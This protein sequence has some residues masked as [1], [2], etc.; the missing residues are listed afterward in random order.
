MD[1]RTSPAADSSDPADNKE[2]RNESQ[3]G[4]DSHDGPDASRKILGETAPAGPSIPVRKAP[5]V[6]RR[7]SLEGEDA[8]SAGEPKR[9]L[10]SSMVE[11]SEKVG[12]A[13]DPTPAENKAAVKSRKPS[14]SGPS[15][16]QPSP[17]G[18]WSHLT[19]Y[20]DGEYVS[21]P[22]RKTRADDDAGVDDATA[23]EKEI[24]KEANDSDP[25]AEDNDDAP[26]TTA[27]EAQT[28]ALDTPLRGSPAPDFMDPAAT[29]SPA[30]AVDDPDDGDMSDSQDPPQRRRCFKYRKLRD[31]EE[32]LSAIENY[33]DMTT[34]ELYGVL[35]AINVSLVQWQT[36]WTD[37]GKVV[38]DYENSLR[39]RAAD[40]KY[41]SRT[42]NLAQHGVNH[43]EPDF[44]V[45]GYKA[46]E[47]ELMSETR[48]L[49]GQDRIMAA[50]Y[51]FE[52]DPHPSKIGRQNPETQQ[53][54]IMTRGRT[55]RNQPR[56]TVKA[57]EADEVTGKRQRKPVQLFDP[58]AQDVSRSST[59]VPL[60]RG[61]R[62]RN[63][64]ADDD[65]QA[66]FTSSFNGDGNSDADSTAPKP[67][68]RRGPRASQ[69]AA[70]AAAEE[71]TT[72]PGS[73]V[74]DQEETGRSGR[75]RAKQPVRYDD[76][77]PD[78]ADED[79]QPE[80]KQAKRML[81]LKMPRG[82]NFSEQS[83][84]ITDNGDSRPSTAS[85]ASSS[86]TIESSYSFR[87]KRQKRFRDD[88]DESEEA[89]LQAPPRKRGKRNSGTE[90]SFLLDEHMVEA[91]QSGS[92]RKVPKIKVVRQSG[93]SMRNGT[94][95]SATGGD[96][97]DK[98]KDYKSMT[99]SEKMSASM[100]S[101]CR[102]MAFPLAIVSSSSLT[103]PLSSLFSLSPLPLL[104][105]RSLPFPPQRL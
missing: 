100:K 47:R 17:Q 25:L 27:H 59:P 63:V 68:R 23:E 1:S 14:H 22:E 50:T 8:F 5:D 74:I 39:R 53:D 2:E 85:S 94:P 46:K 99:K 9:S 87:P 92:A 51:G 18:R 76:T 79:S 73:S 66:T 52:Y 72:P 89:A 26:D 15:K 19:P 43:E 21:Y 62:R 67:R 81:T 104:P 71:L 101:E 34:A 33:G 58:A 61:R 91:P 57:S 65:G 35:Q 78:F 41:E 102:I 55:L 13:S 31:P 56:Q 64:N 98:P 105:R 10:A 95:S 60:G 28:P 30:P 82:K 48:Y 6:E 20:V 38:D 36:E 70:A 103:P 86:H 84:A 83:S 24:D 11:P 12:G 80:P 77:Y 3:N 97:D 96:G 54:G 4:A 29:N 32:Y 49:Q 16:P 42:R 45:K 93:E 7:G 44:V 88:P 37:M 75:R 69:A 40:T 90:S